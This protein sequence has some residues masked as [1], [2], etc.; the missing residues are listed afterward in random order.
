MLKK[1]DALVMTNFVKNNIIKA[2]FKHLQ[3]V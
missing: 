1:E 2:N 3:D